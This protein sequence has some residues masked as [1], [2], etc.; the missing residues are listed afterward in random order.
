[1]IVSFNHSANKHLKDL[2]R[3][4]CEKYYLRIWNENLFAYSR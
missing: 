2:Q 4:Y 1:M 3:I